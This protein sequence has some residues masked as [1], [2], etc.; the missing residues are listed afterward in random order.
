MLRLE[1]ERLDSDGR[2]DE[3]DPVLEFAARHI[4]HAGSVTFEVVYTGFED[5]PDVVTV[6]RAGDVS[7]A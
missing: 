4:G 7:C 6:T 2:A 5:V 1:I 3:P